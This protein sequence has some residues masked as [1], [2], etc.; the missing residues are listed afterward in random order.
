MRRIFDIFGSVILIFI[1]SPLIILISILLRITSKGPV[2]FWAPRLGLDEN[3]FEMPKFRTFKEGTPI[4]ASN[5]IEDPESLYTPMGGF[6]RRFSIDE[7]PQLYCILRGDMTFIGPRPCLDNQED[8]ISLRKKH[9]LFSIKPGVSGW[10]QINGRDE[11][12]LEKKIE[13]D[14]EYFYRRSFFFDL[15]IIWMTIIKVIKSDNI[16]H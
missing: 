15:K 13:L 12:S 9:N 8:L 4:L 3:K 5:L 11:I 1:L 6:L 2:L 16:S 7:L 10:A 14:L